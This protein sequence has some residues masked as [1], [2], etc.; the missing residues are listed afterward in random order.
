MTSSEMVFVWTDS[1]RLAG[2]VLIGVVDDGWSK[3]KIVHDTLSRLARVVTVRHPSFFVLPFV[4]L[5][6]ATSILLLRLVG[7]ST[8]GLANSRDLV[9][10]MQYT[11]AVTV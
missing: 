6:E 7:Q 11:R 5:N 4:L 10:I 9:L 2:Q 3:A 1:H 8:E